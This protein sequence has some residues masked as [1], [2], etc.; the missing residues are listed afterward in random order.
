[1]SAP[2]TLEVTAAG[3][4]E[5]TS[6]EYHRHPALSSSGARMLLPPSCPALFRHERDNG[7]KPKRDFDFGHAAHREVLGIG[8][9][10][11]IIDKGGYKTSAAQDERDQAYADGKVPLLAKEY[12]V[13]QAMAEA[14]RNHPWAGALFNP[15]RGG[16]PEQSLF[17]TDAETGVECRARLDWLPDPD[18]SPR[19]LVVPDY[20]TSKAADPVS[21]GKSL[22]EYGYARQA[23][24]YLDGIAALGLAERAAFIF[25]V[26]MKEAPYLVTVAEPDAEALLVGRTYNRMARET[27]AECAAADRWPGFSDD[28]PAYVSMP[29]WA[30]NRFYEETGL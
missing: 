4:Y 10:L 7:R 13:V 2:T 14:L 16:K 20:K 23:A 6:E 28:G 5:M 22:H 25:V 30:L 8:E 12:A 29:G 1:M 27:F 11:V 17:W 24:W 26:Q 3:V 21:I 9:E 18:R 19:R 15:E